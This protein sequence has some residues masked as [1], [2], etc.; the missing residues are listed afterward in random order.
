MLSS[1]KCESWIMDGSPACFSRS[2]EVILSIM[3]FESGRQNYTGWRFRCNLHRFIKIGQKIAEVRPLYR[4]RKAFPHE[5]RTANQSV[6][7]KRN[8]RFNHFIVSGNLNGKTHFGI[9]DQ[10]S[11]T[12]SSTCWRLRENQFSAGELAGMRKTL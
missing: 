2:C 3:D 4:P 1:E 7:A 8:H 11:Q 10:T 6:N 9:R 12:L 5:S